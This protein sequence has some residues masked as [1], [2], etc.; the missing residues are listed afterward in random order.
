MAI[1]SFQK[2]KKVMSD[3]QYASITADGAPPG[4]YTP[5]M[6]EED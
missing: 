2:P 5:N 3:K 4:V 6:S 1:L